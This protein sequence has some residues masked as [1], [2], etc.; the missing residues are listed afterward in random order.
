MNPLPFFLWAGLGVIL[1]G[2]AI[3]V[4]G[5]VL[6]P[7]ILATLNVLFSLAVLFLMFRHRS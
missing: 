4:P 6:V 1:M 2:V 7:L 3:F 5:P